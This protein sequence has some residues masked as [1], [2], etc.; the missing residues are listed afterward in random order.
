MELAT[1][2]AQLGGKGTLDECRALVCESIS[3]GS[4]FA[5]LREIVAALGG[6]LSALD[7][8]ALLPQAPCSR[9]VHAP[10]GGYVWA[11]DTE[12]VGTASVV[13]G[14]GRATKEDSIDYAAGIVLARKTGDA[15][16][17]GEVI[18]TLFAARLSIDLYE[19]GQQE[20]T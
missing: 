15:V 3:N 14:A 1:N 17:E 2:M 13:L 6:N 10:R 8:P 11:M 4:A 18:A 20:E 12:R 9:E 7:D 16:A 5:K 19:K